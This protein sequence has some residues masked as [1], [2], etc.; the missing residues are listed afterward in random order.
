[1]SALSDRVLLAAQQELAKG[2][3][4][5]V[6]PFARFRGTRVD[7]YQ[8]AVGLP[9][10]PNPTV[11]AFP[12]CAAAVYTLF[13]EAV[14]AMNIEASTHLVDGLG[15]GVLT[16]PCPRTGSALHLWR[17]ATAHQTSQASPGCVFVLDRGG[18]HGH[19][20]FVEQALSPF[21][22]TTVEPDTSSDMSPTG[23]S[24]GRHVGWNTNGRHGMT[25]LGYLQ[26]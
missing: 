16:N 18:G 24:W 13:S 14:T 9:V 25:L 12:W 20:G 4:G 22:L 15:S 8:R 11:P 26:F 7:E 3:R 10:P 23:D 21:V 5:G 19:V 1:L 2:V 6:K 17:N